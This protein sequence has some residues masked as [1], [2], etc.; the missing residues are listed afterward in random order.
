MK[1]AR[2]GRLPTDISESETAAFQFAKGVLEQL[3]KGGGGRVKDE[4]FEKAKGVL[5]RDRVAA[6]MHTVASF[7]YS[8]VLMNA[9]DVEA[10]EALEE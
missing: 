8:G 2:E 7:M 6:V 9:G 5:G 10:P 4:V 3:V 1:D